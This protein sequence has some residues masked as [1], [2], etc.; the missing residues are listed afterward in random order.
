[1]DTKRG[2]NAS[3]KTFDK[4]FKLA[5]VKLILEDQPVKMIGETLGVHP[6]SLYRW[7]QEY[8]KYARQ[9]KLM[10]IRHCIDDD[11]SGRFF[12]RCSCTQMINGEKSGKISIVLMKDMT[13]WRRDYLQVRNA[14][15]IF[16]RNNVLQENR[17]LT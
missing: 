13:R 10:N 6:N 8:E 7:I 2:N 16:R 5:A 17:R 9:Y 1:M 11:E 14:M 12:D 15:E 3:R 4:A